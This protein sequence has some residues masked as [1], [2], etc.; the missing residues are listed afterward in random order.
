MLILHTHIQQSYVIML[1]MNFSRLRTIQ[2]FSIYSTLFQL[3]K[4]SALSEC[5]NTL[6]IEVLK[7]QIPGL[8]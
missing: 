7:V 1:M 8:I 3:G 2:K 6:S 4:F 5:L